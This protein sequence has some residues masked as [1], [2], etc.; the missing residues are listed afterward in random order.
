MIIVEVLVQ[1]MRETDTERQRER[2]AERDREREI[3]QRRDRQTN[4]GGSTMKTAWRLA[5]TAFI[6]R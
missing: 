1:E 3:D 2:E 6:L 4:R 5:P